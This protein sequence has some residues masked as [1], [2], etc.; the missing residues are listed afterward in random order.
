MQIISLG[1]LNSKK[2]LK[3]PKGPI[4]WDEAMA[5]VGNDEDFLSEVNYYL[6]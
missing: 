6:Y 2:L 3:M 1:I 5:Q 4:N